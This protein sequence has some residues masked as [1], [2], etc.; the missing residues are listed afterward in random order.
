[1][2]GRKFHPGVKVYDWER[3]IQRHLNGGNITS[4]DAALIREYVQERKH[5]KF[6][7]DARVNKITSILVN[8]RQYLRVPYADAAPGDIYSAMD[9]LRDSGK[10]QNTVHDFI[11]ILKPFLLWLIDNEYSRMPEKKIRELTA[12]GVDYNTTEPDEILTPDE[13]LQLINACR[14][15]RDR[16]V[17]SCLY[18]SGCRSGELALLRWRNL[19]FSDIGIKVTIQ[20]EKEKQRRIAYLTMSREYL[21]AWKNDTDFNGQNDL[22]F[23]TE[24]GEAFQY[25]TLRKIVVKAAKRSN[26]EKHIHLHLFRKSRITHLIQQGYQES[27]VKRSMWGNVGTEMFKTYVCLTDSDIENEF[28]DKAG[29]KMK[30][31]APNPLK[32]RPCPRC[33]KVMGPESMFCSSCGTSLTEEVQA[34]QD[35]LVKVLSRKATE[36]PEGLIKALKAL[37]GN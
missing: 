24:A 34:T 12:P 2:V 25:S 23:V 8:W 5:G 7:S 16:A 1:M 17:I 37:G 26:I 9:S 13:I 20:D 32:A 11:R 29:I 18:E 4:H 35:D 6:L 27:I 28:L 33:H 36:D 14:S 31:E 3:S 19:E 22:V 30:D 21:A 10:M 15:S